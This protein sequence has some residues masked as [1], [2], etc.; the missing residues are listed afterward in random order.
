[1]FRGHFM[2]HNSR[3]IFRKKGGGVLAN[4]RS[5]HGHIKKKK[6]TKGQT[7]WHF[8]HTRCFCI[9]TDS[10]TAARRCKYRF[11]QIP[12]Q[13]HM[14]EPLKAMGAKYE[15]SSQVTPTNLARVQQRGECLPRAE[16]E[17]TFLH[18]SWCMTRDGGRQPSSELRSQH[19]V[20][21]SG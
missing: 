14:Q 10:Y 3:D 8:Y 16:L 17:H 15:P 4:V 20:M 2:S 18:V 19:S 5:W 12:K 9:C 21:S 1:M 13:L 11:N 7:R 6:Q